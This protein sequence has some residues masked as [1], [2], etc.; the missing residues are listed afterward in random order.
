MGK[1]KIS[2]KVDFTPYE[3]YLVQE[4]LRK[5]KGNDNVEVYSSPFVD[6][7]SFRPDIYAPNGLPSL[8]MEGETLVEIKLKLSFSSLKSIEYCFEQCKKKYN[9]L[10]V[11]FRSNLTSV[12][13]LKQYEGH[14]CRFIAFE[15]L[16]GNKKT[17]EARDKY[18][19]RR[20]Q[21]K[22]LEK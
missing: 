13:D 9:L 15:D 10:V 22:R 3:S 20:G 16:K 21:K 8:K 5:C 17:A 1:N 7:L 2:D 18:Y 12:P 14:V 19:L 4:V 11:Y 6:G